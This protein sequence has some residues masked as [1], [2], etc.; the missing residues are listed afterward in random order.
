MSVISHSTVLYCICETNIFPIMIGTK[1]WHF[2]CTMECEITFWK[3]CKFLYHFHMP[4]AEKYLIDIST[5]MFVGHEL[6]ILHQ[7]I[8]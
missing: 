8:N 2:N 1:V 3:S 6:S 7:N 5:V 4:F